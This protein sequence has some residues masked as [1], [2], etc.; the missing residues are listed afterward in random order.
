ML[1]RFKPPRRCTPNFSNTASFRMDALAAVGGE[2][3]GQG[4]EGRQPSLT[5]E[6]GSAA[7]EDQKLPPPLFEMKQNALKFG[8]GTGPDSGSKAPAQ[9]WACT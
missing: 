7:T 8:L 2:G 1:Q 6:D 5:E 9:F 4:C 3:V